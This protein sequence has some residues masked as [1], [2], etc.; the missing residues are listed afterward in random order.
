VIVPIG[1][2]CNVLIL[3]INIAQMEAQLDGHYLQKMKGTPA[4]EKGRRI[5]LLL[6]FFDAAY[7][8][9]QPL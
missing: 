5:W 1:E 8:I 3:A 7:T 2:R 4:L 9:A 6:R